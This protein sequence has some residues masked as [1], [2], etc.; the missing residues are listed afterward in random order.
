MNVKQLKRRLKKRSPKTVARAEKRWDFKMIGD[1]TDFTF[2]LLEHVNPKAKAAL[3]P[4][5]WLIQ[6][7]EI[8]QELWKLLMK[9]RRITQREKHGK[10]P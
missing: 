3:E 1:V 7:P 2:N 8:E 10:L 6:G 4:E 9:V 5:E